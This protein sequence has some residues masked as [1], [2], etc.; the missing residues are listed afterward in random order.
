MTEVAKVETAPTP[1]AHPS[2]PS[3]PVVVEGRPLAA[4]VDPQVTRKFKLRAGAAHNH[5]GKSLAAGDVVDLTA[6]QAEA[7]ADK[8]EPAEAP[9]DEKKETLEEEVVRLR[10]LVAGGVP[11]TPS[12][13][14]RQDIGANTPMGKETL[15]SGFKEEELPASGLKDKEKATGGA[16]PAQP[17]GSVGKAPAAAAASGGAA[18]QGGST[19]DGVGA[20]PKK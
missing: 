18:P 4:A 8:F 6:S 3:Q 5:G 2:G 20:Q 16:H 7:F 17:A 12:P 15:M 14:I 13:N 9:K 10:A 19:D 11:A 1:S